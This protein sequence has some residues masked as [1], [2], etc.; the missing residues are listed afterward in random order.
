MQKLSGKQVFQA[1][2]VVVALLKLFLV[3]D[4]E[5]FGQRFDDMGYAL[6]IIDHYYACDPNQNWLFI[7]PL[8]FPLFGA[9]CM[10]TGIPYRLCIEFLF[11][12]SAYFFCTGLM[13]IISIPSVA[14]VSLL[15][16]VF[17]PWVLVGFN[18]L[19]TEPY[20]LSLM[21][22]TLGL[23]LRL[24][25][26]HFWRW[27]NPWLWLLGPLLALMMLTRREEPWVFGRVAL[28][29]LL[30]ILLVRF[31]QGKP[32]K[33]GVRQLWLVLVP[34]GCYAAIMLLVS[35]MNYAKWGIFATNEQQAPGFS[36]LLD[37]LY[38]IDT[39]DPSLWAPVTSKTLEMAMEAS[40]RFAQLRDGMFDTNNPHLEYGE[41][42]TGREG[43][44]GAWMWWR[45]YDSLASSG[46]YASPKEADAWMLATA[47][48]LEAA[49]ADGRLPKRRFSTSFPV[50][51]NFGIWIPE[52]PRLF[53]NTLKRLH[54]NRTEADFTLKEAE[55]PAMYLPLFDKAANRRTS[56]I[57]ANSVEI[58][59][60]AFSSA[61]RLDFIAVENSL[62]EMVAATAPQGLVYFK[63]ADIERLTGKEGIFETAFHIRFVP[64]SRGPFTLSLWKDGERLHSYPLENRQYPHRV[65]T[66]PADDQVAVDQTVL[67]FT[68][69]FAD[70]GESMKALLRGWGYTA[71]GPL[72][73]VSL[74]NEKGQ[75]LK[76][77]AFRLKRDDI[78]PMFRD[79]TGEDALTPLGF[80]IETPVLD[81]DAITVQF[82]KDKLLVHE[83]ALADLPEGRWGTVESTS[84]GVPLTIGIG[85]RQIPE[86]IEQGVSLRQQIRSHIAWNYY[87]YVVIAACVF[88]VG[89]IL[90]HLF[91]SAKATMDRWKTGAVLL[92]LALFLLGRAGF[93]GLVEAAVVPGVDRYMDCASPIAS[94]LL[95]LLVFVPVIL[96]YEIVLSKTGKSSKGGGG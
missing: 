45:L 9:L 54:F 68:S 64:R 19:L 28:L 25:A 72:T 26:G 93:Y 27:S 96:V 33:A 17:H 55:V 22:L 1:V 7:R 91:G 48:E 6:S 74:V 43:E 8:G 34:V 30:R 12:A 57:A 86:L 58:T 88:G 79:A 10:E 60:H 56:L 18:Q 32:W 69:P 59:G 46:V 38:K 80:H 4:Q 29:F 81:E 63:R 70:N 40:P 51:P 95:A 66:K 84:S 23:S 89:G 5:I 83:L 13:R 15:T 14:I 65:I 42:T 41:M 49:M 62:G 35:G 67:S 44:L 71:L 3:G 11:L 20:F 87:I 50:D 77:E 92:F 47:E 85:K 2:F 16:L 21:L 78:K 39:P 37:T 76:L 90:F 53:L 24:M 73:H 31:Q 94:V 82:W 61:G 36:G 75:F 52:F